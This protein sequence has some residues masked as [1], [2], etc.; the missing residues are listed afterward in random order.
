[1]SIN[2]ITA[3]SS[4]YSYFTKYQYQFFGTTISEIKFNDL[5]KK[6]GITPN[7][8]NSYE[9]VEALYNAMYAEAKAEAI[10]AV[11]STRAQSTPQS[12]QSLKA[13]NST[14]APW[15]FLM[16]RIGL[17]ATG[18]LSADSAAFT[19]K[20]SALQ[21][22]GATSQEQIAY[23][24]QLMSE[25]SVVFV[26]TSSTIAQSTPSSSAQTQRQ[27]VT[28]ADIKAQLNRMYFFS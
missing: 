13:A 10:G 1:M 8:G 14:N 9:T 28:G 18:N 20:I 3:I 15:T 7:I 2:A 16:S 22:S 5:L 4:D 24:N 23:I 27:S 25:A 26:Q 19:S 6:Y 17:S 21:S 12:S 11:S